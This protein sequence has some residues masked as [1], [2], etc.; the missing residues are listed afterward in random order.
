MIGS[1]QTEVRREYAGLDARFGLPLRPLGR[2][3]VI[4]LAFVAFGGFFAWS[5]ARDLWRTASSLIE[6]GSPGQE[7][8]LGLLF[9]VPFLLVGAVPLTLGLLVLFGRCRVEWRNGRVRSAEVL[10]PFWWTRRLPPKPLRR[11]TV[12]ATPSGGSPAPPRGLQELA[13]LFAEYES[14]PR[15]IVA[16][17]YPREWLL[18]LARE[19]EILAGA[20]GVTDSPVEVEV[21]ERWS[22][23]DD[24]EAEVT[25]QPRHSRVGLEERSSGLRLTVPPAGLW[26]GSKG[27]FFFALVWCAFVAAFTV[28][29]ARAGFEH[30]GPSWM[31]VLV[32]SVFWLF[33]LGLLTFAINMGRRTAVISAED[34]RLQV[35]VR[36][37]FGV[38]RREWGPGELTAIRADSGFEVN[39]RPVLELQIHPLDGKKWGMLAGRDEDELRWMAT[40][41]RR[42][43]ALPA[44]GASGPADDAASHAR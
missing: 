39:D 38:T 31:P 23:E 8:G 35:E 5:P 34:G 11:L 27:M 28:G 2:A 3:R 6:T 12:V 43:L 26:R 30:D 18:A 25:E 17:G 37:L 13:A 4:G 44:R 9:Q 10:G 20:R 16:L 24:A 41:L 33:G 15:R 29:A 19:L 1:W 36:G 32:I 7:G 14:G 21:V 22:P 40:R 42:A